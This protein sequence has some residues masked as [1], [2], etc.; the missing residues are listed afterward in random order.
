M[1][2]EP[3]DGR[4]LRCAAS[5]QA[6]TVAY[7]PNAVADRLGTH[8]RLTSDRIEDIAAHIAEFSI[9]GLDGVR[10]VRRPAAVL[11]SDRKATA[12]VRAAGGRRR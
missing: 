7:L 11:R 6:Q 12:A 1:G 8:A 2:C 5:I 3:S 9:A 10:R 4:V